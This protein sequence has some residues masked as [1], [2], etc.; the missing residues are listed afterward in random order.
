MFKGFQEADKLKYKESVV[1]HL[2]VMST[3]LI[4]YFYPRANI[5]EKNCSSKRSVCYSNLKITSFR[6]FS[7]PSPIMMTVKT[8]PPT[9]LLSLPFTIQNYTIYNMV[10]CSISNRSTRAYY[11]IYILHIC[12]SSRV[13]V[14]NI[15][16]QSTC[17][18]LWGKCLKRFFMGNRLW[19]TY[20]IQNPHISCDS[21][22]FAFVSI[23]VLSI[24][25]VNWQNYFR[26][27]SQSLIKLNI[28][29]TQTWKH[30]K[31]RT[32]TLIVPSFITVQT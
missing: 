3:I 7:E 26:Q 15:K 4:K 25:N 13:T 12:A 17:M 2:H 23:S 20:W 28:A 21:S 9:P 10:T 11:S 1:L 14:Q 8:C 30:T 32:Q 29:L 24:G 5:Q 16:P 19:L 18:V 6:F 22:P 31:S 27:A